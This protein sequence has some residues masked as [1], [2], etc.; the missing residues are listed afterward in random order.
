MTHVDVV[1]LIEKPVQGYP[2]KKEIFNF[3]EKTINVLD[4]ERQISLLNSTII[5]RENRDS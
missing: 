2:V 4:I 3:T 5:L 1:I